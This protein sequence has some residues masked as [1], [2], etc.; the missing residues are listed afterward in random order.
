MIAGALAG[1]SN[2]QIARELHADAGAVAR[3]VSQPEVRLS[4]EGYRQELRGRKLGWRR[5]HGQ[6]HRVGLA[7][8]DLDG[9]L[10]VSGVA[11]DVVR[12]FVAIE[13]LLDASPRT[14]ALQ[15]LACRGH[16]YPD[17]QWPKA[18]CYGRP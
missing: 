14:P 9:R 16:L 2:R 6:R 15:A 18:P 3:V 17:H 8:C 4:L 11:E 7:G 13:I 5:R 12:M 1:K 10:C